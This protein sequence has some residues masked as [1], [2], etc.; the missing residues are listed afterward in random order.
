VKLLRIG[1]R[2]SITEKSDFEALCEA[3]TKEKVNFF[4]YHTAETRPRKI[5]LSGLPNKDVKELLEALEEND[6]IPEG[7]KQ[8]ELHSN[9]YAYDQ[10]SVNLLYFKPGS[11]KMSDLQNIKHINHIKEIT[12]C[13]VIAQ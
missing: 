5:V 13:M 8:L 3:L 6:I 2:V 10:Q 7:I 12:R 4:K 9:R 11:I 1:I